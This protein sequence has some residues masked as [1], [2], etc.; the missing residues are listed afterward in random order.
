MSPPARGCTAGVY[1]GRGETS[2][3]ASAPPWTTTNVL[4]PAAVR[5]TSRHQARLVGGLTGALLS[6][7]PFD[8]RCS[9]Q[10]IGLGGHPSWLPGSVRC[11]RTQ[12]PPGRDPR[13]S[14]AAH[15]PA[16][17]PQ[18]CNNAV[19]HNLVIQASALSASAVQCGT[20]AEADLGQSWIQGGRHAGW[21]S[22][23]VGERSSIGCRCCRL[24]TTKSCC[25]VGNWVERA[26]LASWACCH[27]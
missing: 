14:V 21:L 19:C 25:R 8:A 23:A 12:K 7:P 4:P 9:G 18:V 13:Y 22:N 27:G 6:R 1:L 11:P 3:P 10:Q 2:C 15:T 26:H 24:E 20:S 16:G 5:F 17:N